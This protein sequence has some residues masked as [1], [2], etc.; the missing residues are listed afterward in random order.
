MAERLDLN[1]LK[2]PSALITFGAVG[3]SLLILGFIIEVRII[4]EHPAYGD[5][6]GIVQGLWRLILGIATL[7]SFSLAVHNYRRDDDS[8]GPS[9]QFSVRGRDHDIDF[10]VHIGGPTESRGSAQQQEEGEVDDEEPL[11]DSTSE[12]DET[13]ISEE[14]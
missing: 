1:R 6:T 9:T 3:L 7:G 13:D 5:V 14:G 12:D 2:S 11:P 8:T 10:H 4:F